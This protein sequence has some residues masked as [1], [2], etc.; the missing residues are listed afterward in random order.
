M[1]KSKTDLNCNN[2]GY[3]C[4]KCWVNFLNDLMYEQKFTFFDKEENVR[5]TFRS[6]CQYLKFPMHLKRKEYN[7][8]HL[9]DLKNL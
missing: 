8:F 1:S 4:R 7:L 2:F 6:K 5:T 9:F 3:T